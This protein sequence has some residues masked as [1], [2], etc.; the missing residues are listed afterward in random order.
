MG[1]LIFLL[2]YLLQDQIVIPVLMDGFFSFPVM[3]NTQIYLETV[4]FAVSPVGSEVN[5]MILYQL[6]PVVSFQEHTEVTL[7]TALVLKDALL[8]LY[9]LFHTQLSTM[10]GSSYLDLGK[11]VEYPLFWISSRH[12]SRVFLRMATFVGFP[13]FPSKIRTT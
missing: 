7:L 11:Q 1:L 8:F 10:T 13:V 9:S 5:V 4:Y 12:S 6:F 2:A 3:R